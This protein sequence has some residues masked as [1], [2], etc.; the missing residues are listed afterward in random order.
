MERYE[1]LNYQKKQGLLWLIRGSSLFTVLNMGLMTQEYMYP[2]MGGM[3]LFSFGLC[4]TIGIGLMMFLKIF[5]KRTVNEMFLL[6][7]G[8]FVEIKY[9]NAF[10]LPIS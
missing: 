8:D 6:K 3:N 2:V 5:S 10:W 7:S 4:T 9:F 1:Y